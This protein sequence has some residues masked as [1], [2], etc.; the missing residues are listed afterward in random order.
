MLTSVAHKK[1]RF[2]TMSWDW[3]ADETVII[4]LVDDRRGKSGKFKAEVADG[5]VVKILEDEEMR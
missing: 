1:D 3:Q 4:T 2:N 5:K